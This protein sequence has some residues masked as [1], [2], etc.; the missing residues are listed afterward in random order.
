MFILPFV[1]AQKMDGKPQYNHK[2]DV[3]FWTK[4]QTEGPFLTSSESVIGTF[5]KLGQVDTSD[6]AKASFWNLS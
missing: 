4:K 1:F 2:P 3:I 5:E 6:K